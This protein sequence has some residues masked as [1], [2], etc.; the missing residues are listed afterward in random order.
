MN[1]AIIPSER[2]DE[3]SWNYAIPVGSWVIPR[4]EPDAS[5]KEYIGLE[6]TSFNPEQTDEIMFLEG[7]IFM[8]SDSFFSWRDQFGMVNGDE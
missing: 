7:L 8:D 6:G 5:T 4:I 2:K 1:Y 3:I